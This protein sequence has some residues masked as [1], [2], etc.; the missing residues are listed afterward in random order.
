MHVIGDAAVSQGVRALEAALLDFP[1]DDHRHTLIHACLIQPNDLK[2]IAKLGIGI[3]LQ[4]GFFVSPLEP[5]EYLTE[6]LGDRVKGSSPLR[7]IL[8]APGAGLVSR[9]DIRRKHNPRGL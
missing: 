6:I 1:R 5:V 9:N 3:T 2:K 7:S 4:P 8:D